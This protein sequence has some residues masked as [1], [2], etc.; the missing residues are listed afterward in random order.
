MEVGHGPSDFMLDGDS[1]PPQ[2]GGGVPPQFL[3]NVHCAKRLDGS[4]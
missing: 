1:A 3:A 4:K 2:K